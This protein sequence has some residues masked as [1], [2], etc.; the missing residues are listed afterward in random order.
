MGAENYEIIRRKIRWF[1]LHQS[2]LF[3]TPRKEKKREIGMLKIAQDLDNRCPIG[4]RRLQKYLSL[5][6]SPKDLAI[7]ISD[8]VAFAQMADLKVSEFVE[9]IVE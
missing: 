9:Q 2:P 5:H 6:T 3:L 4:V 1:L 7:G 8:L